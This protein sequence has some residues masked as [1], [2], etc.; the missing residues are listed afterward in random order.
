MHRYR[1]PSRRCIANG[2]ATRPETPGW[3]TK[4]RL[5]THQPR[6]LLARR[7]EC[8]VSHRASL[9]AGT[10]PPCCR[11]RRATTRG[12]RFWTAA[13]RASGS[14]FYGGV[15]AAQDCRRPAHGTGRARAMWRSSG[16]RAGAVGK[17][18]VGQAPRSRTVCPLA[19]T[20]DCTN[21]PHGHTS[22]QR[23]A[24]FCPW[25][26]APAASRMQSPPSFP[27]P[28]RQLRFRRTRSL[29]RLAAQGG[30]PGRAGF[31]GSGFQRHRLVA[32]CRTAPSSACWAKPCWS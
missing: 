29:C 32:S 20:S 27:D 3:L 8:S 24:L 25:R 16:R 23:R 10:A 7:V 31:G 26:A 14:A 30:D 2:T 5:R 1:P 19:K 11:R 12:H 18:A 6:V 15:P 22:P 17:S 9:L 21:R 28:C 4:G 13:A